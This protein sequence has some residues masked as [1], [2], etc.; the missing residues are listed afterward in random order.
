MTRFALCLTLLFTQQVFAAN[1]GKFRLTVDADYMDASKVE[2]LLNS[3]GE[4]ET[5]SNEDYFEVEAL[6]FF[7]ELT[8]NFRSGDED[9]ILASFRLVANQVLS[10]CSAYV[11]QPNQVQM[12]YPLGHARLER[13]N[14]AKKKYESIT[15]SEIRSNE[16]QCLAELLKDY[17]HYDQI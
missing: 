2:F 10:A 1:Y 5:L 16:E 12:P 17:Q 9:L 8:L 15:S 13:W 14:K 6:P 11:D 4:I 7:G 3:A